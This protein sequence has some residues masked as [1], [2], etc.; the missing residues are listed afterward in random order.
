MG[1]LAALSDRALHIGILL[2]YH[3]LRQRFLRG[4]VAQGPVL[5]HVA[6]GLLWVPA[7]LHG[8]LLLLLLWWLGLDLA[9]V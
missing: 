6:G 9:E 1:L 8:L 2:L 5:L 4:Y 7:Y 3:W